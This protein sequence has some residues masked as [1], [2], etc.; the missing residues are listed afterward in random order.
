MRQFQGRRFQEWYKKLG[1]Q[2]SF[3][4]VVC[5]QSNGQVEVVNWDLVRDLKV[6]LDQI[7]GS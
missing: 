7:K 4:S 5:P 2:Q 6:K 3:I 1:I